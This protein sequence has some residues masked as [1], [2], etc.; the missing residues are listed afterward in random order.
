MVSS[1]VALVAVTVH[2]VVE[3]ILVLLGVTGTGQRHVARRFRHECD[4]Q[5][6][7]GQVPAALWHEPHL[8][9]LLPGR[10][11]GADD[12]GQPHMVPPWATPGEGARLIPKMRAP[13]GAVVLASRMR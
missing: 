8:A 1:Y 10:L 7:R 2:S 3:P 9:E 13:S 6:Q 4:R 12:H 11:R 5:M